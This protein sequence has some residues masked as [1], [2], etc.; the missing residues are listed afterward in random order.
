MLE[1]M[2]DGLWDGRTRETLWHEV[3]RVYGLDGLHSDFSA[4]IKVFA[5]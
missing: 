1:S 4:E 5:D 2:A 3:R